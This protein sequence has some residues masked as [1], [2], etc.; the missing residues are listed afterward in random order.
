[1]AHYDLPLD[2]PHAGRIAGRIVEL[3]ERHCEEHGIDAP[4]VFDRAER[5]DGMLFRFVEEDENPGEREA[6]EMREKAAAVAR[7]LVDALEAAQI[8]GD[9]LGQYVRNL[10]ECLELGEEGAQI[11]L[12]VGEKP[13]S[14]MRAQ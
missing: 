3:L 14:L 6:A 12:R 13:D 2:L 10:F 7:Q 11:S 5:L 4:E 9:R 8:A 1:M